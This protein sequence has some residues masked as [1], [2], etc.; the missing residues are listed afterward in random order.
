M[1]TNTNQNTIDRIIDE[2]NPL[3]YM[4]LINAVYFKSDWKEPFDAAN[5][6]AKDFDSP[7]GVLLWIS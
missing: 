1:G 5:T 3:T 2:I 4:F 7:D 6:R